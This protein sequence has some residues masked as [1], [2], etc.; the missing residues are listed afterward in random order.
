M[1]SEIPTYYLID[2]A[3]YWWLPVVYRIDTANSVAPASYLNLA[4]I[5]SPNRYPTNDE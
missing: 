2:R 4:P 5:Y 1:A 3:V